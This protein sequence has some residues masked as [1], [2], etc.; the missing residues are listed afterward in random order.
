[1]D[2]FR[3]LGHVGR[4]A[5]P[6][7]PGLR[8]SSQSP[9]PLHKPFLHPAESPGGHPAHSAPSAVAT[10][11][12]S[13]SSL[14]P[15]HRYTYASLSDQ[16]PDAALGIQN[17]SRGRG[18]T[19]VPRGMLPGAA[20]L[21]AEPGPPAGECFSPGSRNLGRTPEVLGQGV[22]PFPLLWRPSSH[23]SPAAYLPGPL[24]YFRASSLPVSVTPHLVVRPACEAV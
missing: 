13:T 12:L 2:S 19:P 10:G 14:S 3:G 17:Q 16:V 1:M 23:P 18:L 20:L 6:V 4:E 5:G 22:C 15:G 24:S 11:V 21:P 8:M 9:R 7:P